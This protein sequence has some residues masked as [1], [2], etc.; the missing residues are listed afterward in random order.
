[1]PMFTS[2]NLQAQPFAIAFRCQW[3][4]I[5]ILALAVGNSSSDGLTDSIRANA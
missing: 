1:M 3:L 2:L 4:Q 5:G